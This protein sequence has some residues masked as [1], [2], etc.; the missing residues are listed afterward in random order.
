MTDPF[1]KFSVAAASR[2]EK[3][4]VER[5]LQLYLHDFSE[6]LD[7]DDPFGGAD[8][9]G[10]FRYEHF[11][12]YW[13]DPAREPLLIRADGHL[14]GFALLNDW[15]A[16]GLKT[17]RA[18]AEFFIL[19]KFR[20]SGLGQRAATEIIELRPVNWEI[21]VTHNNQSALTFWRSVAAS[22]T[23]F[24][25]REVESDGDRWHGTILRVEPLLSVR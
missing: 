25:C 9:S 5:L 13:Q 6:M 7:A 2:T 18:M 10:V 16:S 12:E 23:G 8:D 22:L 15:S 20:R 19:R 1:F 11:D 24:T 14:V 17:D 21:A 4:I 3:P